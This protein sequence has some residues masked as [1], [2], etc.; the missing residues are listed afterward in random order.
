MKDLYRGIHEFKKCHQP[1]NNLEKDENGDLFADC[2]N[3]LKQ[4]EELLFPLAECA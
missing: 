4:L 3:I 1:R 2:H